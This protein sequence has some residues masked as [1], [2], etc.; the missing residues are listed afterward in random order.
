[1][2]K[3]SDL[4]FYK[5]YCDEVNFD[6]LGIIDSVKCSLYGYDMDEEYCDD[7]TILKLANYVRDVW[8]KNNTDYQLEIG[9]ISDV[10]VENW[11]DIIENNIP[12]RDFVGRCL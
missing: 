5:K 4:D 1:M 6:Y 3:Q 10:V 8:L 2:I 9:T 11:E 7:E 12:P